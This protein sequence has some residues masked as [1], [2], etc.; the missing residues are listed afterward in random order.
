[1]LS[2]FFASSECS[3]WPRNANLR[4]P[5]Q[6]RVRTE[7]AEWEEPRHSGPLMRATVPHFAPTLQHMSPT[8]PSDRPDSVRPPD[9]AL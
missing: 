7:V 3:K 9:L 5:S 2:R 6:E 8:F 4:C 1:M